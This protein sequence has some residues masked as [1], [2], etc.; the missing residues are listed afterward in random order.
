MGFALVNMHY[1]DKD[2]I[3]VFDEGKHCGAN[4]RRPD[5]TEIHLSPPSSVVTASRKPETWSSK[6]AIDKTGVSVFRALA[7]RHALL[8][9]SRC[10]IDWRIYRTK[11]VFWVA[12]LMN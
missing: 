5:P 2:M 4:G 8:G 11:L 3:A 9:H 7:S 12:T 1:H 6:T 10:M